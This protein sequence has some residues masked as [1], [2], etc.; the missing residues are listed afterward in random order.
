MPW[1]E[2]ELELELELSSFTSFQYFIIYITWTEVGLSDGPNPTI[3]FKNYNAWNEVRKKLGHGV[4]ESF[5][6]AFQSL[7]AA[8][9]DKISLLTLPATIV[10]I[11]VISSGEDPMI[12]FNSS[13]QMIL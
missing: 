11:E 8:T 10:V 6:I 1:I 7:S 9:G 13:N 12:L 2:L 3:P 5:T 4:G